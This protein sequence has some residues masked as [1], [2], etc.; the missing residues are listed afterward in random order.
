MLETYFSASKMLWHLRSGPCGP[1]LDGFAAALEQQGYGPETAVRY[2]RAAT[3]VGHVMAERDASVSDMDLAAFEE[4][5][6]TCRC[7][8]A[9]GGRCNHHT[10][11]GAKLFRRHLEEIGVCKP[12]VTPMRP[13][14]PQLV[15]GFKAWLSKHRGASDATIRLYARDAASIMAALATDP[16]R[17]SPTDIRDHVMKRARTWGRGT[18]EK[19]TT[20]LRAF[21]RYLAVQGHCRAGLD[22]AVPAY[23]HWQLAEMPRYLSGEQVSRLIA[24][25]DGDAGARRRDRAIIL[26]LARLGLRAGDVAQLRLIDI[27]WQAGSLR[28]T[29]KSRY[30]VRLPLPQDVGDAIAAYLE[31]RPTCCRSDRV[32]L[33]TI[34]PARPF[35][36]GDGVSS[37]VRRVMKRAGVV[38]PIK[39]AHALR[40][41]AA[42]EMLRHGVP[43]DK[44]GLVLR[45][46]GIDTTARYAKADVALLKQVAQPWPEAF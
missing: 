2:L 40:H 10:I 7:P 44:I 20:S 21:L 22:N 12:A 36:N 43:L 41:T 9:K 26:L 18:I 29:G 33:S 39:G 37:V 3:H 31:C 45:H 19:M 23:A 16:A 4:H 25:C 11:Y 38:A 17:W 6:R 1:Y 32:F 46:S 42:T 5:L 15:V 14:E 35:R 27:E 24:A 8:R 34:A 13:A 28:V 30:E